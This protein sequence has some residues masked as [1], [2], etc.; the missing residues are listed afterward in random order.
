[1]VQSFAWVITMIAMGAVTLCFLWVA[2]GAGNFIVLLGT[3]VGTRKRFA[4]SLKI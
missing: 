4:L 1:M 2:A 3:F